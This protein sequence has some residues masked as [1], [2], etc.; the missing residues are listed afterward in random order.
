MEQSDK[1]HLSRRW[2][3]WWLGEVYVMFISWIT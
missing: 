1:V 3:A 2:N